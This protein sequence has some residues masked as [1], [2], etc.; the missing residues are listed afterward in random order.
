MNIDTVH[1]NNLPFRMM[2]SAAACCN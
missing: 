1:H 2:Q